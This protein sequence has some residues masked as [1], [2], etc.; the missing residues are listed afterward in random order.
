MAQRD[1]AAE[2][3]LYGLYVHPEWKGKGV[4]S[5]LLDAVIAKYPEAKVIR[6]EVLK[7]NTA[8]IVWYQARGF[9][10]YGE[11]QSATGTPNTAASYMDKK[12]D[13]ISGGAASTT[14]LTSR[15]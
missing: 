15:T 5:A 12:L 10:I 11:T 2:I 14:A 13:R 3:V 7:G 6:L 8:A 9:E 4:G 1:D